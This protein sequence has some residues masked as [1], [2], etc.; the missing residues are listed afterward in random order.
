MTV[1]AINLRLYYIAVR[2]ALAFRKGQQVGF[3]SAARLNLVNYAASL[4]QLGSARVGSSS[5]AVLLS[6]LF[7]FCF[8]YTLCYG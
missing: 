5:M 7:H 6:V 2:C 4:I 8:V 3:S 1:K